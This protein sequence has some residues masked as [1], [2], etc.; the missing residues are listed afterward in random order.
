[1]FR[2]KL[3]IT[4]TVFTLLL[5]AT[6][7]SAPGQ[8]VDILDS[9][10]FDWK[11]EMDLDPTDVAQINLDAAINS[12]TSADWR[13]DTST[14]ATFA[15]GVMSMSTNTTLASGTAPAFMWPNIGFGGANGFTLEMMFKTLGGNPNQT[16]APM[17]I[18]LNDVGG[19]YGMMLIEPSRLQW[20]GPT[21]FTPISA[22]HNSDGFH[23]VRIAREADADGGKWW[24]W[25][26]D[27]LLTPSGTTSLG[28]GI[29]NNIYFGPGISTSYAGTLDVEYF[30]LTEG[31]YK[32]IEK[33][34]TPPTTIKTAGA[35]DLLYNMDVDPTD[36]TAIDLD[37]DN[38]ADWATSTGPAVSID[39]PG[40]LTIPNDATLQSGTAGAGIWPSQSFTAADGLTFEIAMQLEQTPEQSET[41]PYVNTFVIALSDSDE[42]TA[43]F[44]GDDS[45]RWGSENVL[46]DIDNTDMQHLFRVARDSDADGGRWW[47]W[48]DGVLVSEN[49]FAPSN[50]L[51]YLDSVYFGPGVSGASAG[52]VYV[53]YVGLT[54]GSFAPEEVVY[55][56]GDANGDGVVNA[57]DAAVLAANWQTQ[58]GA[59]WAMGDFNDDGRVDDIDAT[60]LAANW[61]TAA[62]ASVP[63]PGCLV[64]IVC[65][66]LAFFVRRR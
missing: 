57:A 43:F 8:I 21:A 39:S 30:R 51:P 33:V 17:I 62:A 4:S 14:P 52:T 13:Y 54:D 3:G 35:F 55:I 42:A 22:R 34:Y 28:T 40:I 37:D 60:I 10:N 46:T 66:L 56:P 9:S 53:D 11:Y 63:E 32:P 1:M 65:G 26:D 23:S 47:M 20:H 59:S 41:Y 12:N 5:V 50:I 44:I 7:G 38:V 61:Q 18:G 36:P 24:V 48:R 49:G 16:V 6:A 15:A 64:L 27:E 58:S 29:G 25:R 45:I 19:E 31:A 2:E